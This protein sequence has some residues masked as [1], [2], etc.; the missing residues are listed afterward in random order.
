MTPRAFRANGDL[1]KRALINF[2]HKGTSLP[3]CILLASAAAII[4]LCSYR[5][6]FEPR[7]VLPPYR[8]GTLEVTSG[9]YAVPLPDGTYNIYL[10]DNLCEHVD[11]LEYYG[12]VPVEYK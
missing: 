2:H 6:T 4:Y 9:L 1:S 7:Y 11:S 10:G 5:F 12:D 8:L 3:L